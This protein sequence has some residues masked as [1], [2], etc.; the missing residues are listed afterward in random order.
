MEETSG[1]NPL[2]RTSAGP[3]RGFGWSNFAAAGRVDV[4]RG[5]PSPDW[6]AMKTETTHNNATA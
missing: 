6:L 4:G 1:S 5:W 2:I 3:H